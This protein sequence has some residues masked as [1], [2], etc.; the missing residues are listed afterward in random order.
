MNRLAQFVLIGSLAA[1]LSACA[2]DPEPKKEVTR[3]KVVW[4]HGTGE[5]ITVEKLIKRIEENP[6]QA[7]NYFLLGHWYETNN[8]LVLAIQA[9]QAGMARFPKTQKLRY[10]AGETS[11]VREAELNYT[12]GNYRVGRCFAKLD[13]YAEA[14]YYLQKVVQLWPRM[15][16]KIPAGTT[17][18]QVELALEKDQKLARQNPHF[19]NSHYML[20]ACYKELR[21][22]KLAEYH[23]K[24]FVDLGG[25]ESRVLHHLAEI[26][27]ELATGTN[28]DGFRV[29]KSR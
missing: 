23:L 13:R 14:V 26:E 20:G 18:E 8:Q 12:G 15:P 16:D 3:S 7:K 17:R 22:F 9:Y 11:V 2:L 24:R 10:V 25:D 28:R 19:R 21:D 6:D 5:K 1:A 29:E 27:L 4:D